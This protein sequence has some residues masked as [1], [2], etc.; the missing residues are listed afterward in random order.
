MSLTE[1]TQR[2]GATIAS[3]IC[4]A[5]SGQT[6]GQGNA[7]RETHRVIPAGEARISGVMGIQTSL[8]HKLMTDGLV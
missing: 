2:Q 3:V 7:S 8:G 6:L 5:G 1:T 4:S